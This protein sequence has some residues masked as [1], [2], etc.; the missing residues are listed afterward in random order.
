MSADPEVQR[1]LGGVRTPYDAFTTLATHAGHWA[2]RGYGSWAVERREDGTFLGRVGLFCPDEWPGIE[3]GWKFARHAWGAGYATE[4]ARSAMGWAWAALGIERLV[5]LIDVGN[6][7]SARVAQRLGMAAAD[8]IDLQGHRAVVYAIAAPEREEALAL[9]RAT[10]DDAP[11]IHAALQA[12]FADYRSIS[13]PGWAPPD[14]GVEREAEYLAQDWY[15]CAVAEPG[16][17]LA[18]HTAW[19]P[20]AEHRAGTDDPGLAHLRHVFVAPGWWGSPVASRL[21]AEAVRQARDAGFTAMRL[22]TPQAQGRARRFY[23]REGFRTDGTVIDD[24]GFGLPMV[25][26]RLPLT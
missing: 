11:R 17:V 12:A 14:E 10:A 26:Y 13:P 16:G 5:S 23:E 2:L 22:A 25:E 8:E 19:M 1:F 9:R 7:A 24:T 6:V 3:L 20:G 4:A 21:V 15:R 18:G